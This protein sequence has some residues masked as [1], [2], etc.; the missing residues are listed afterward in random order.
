MATVKASRH[1]RCSVV[2]RAQL[3]WR[4]AQKFGGSALVAAGLLIAQPALADL[5][6][7]EY[8]AGGEFGRGT[9]QQYGEATII[10]RDFSNQQLQRSNFTAAD[11]RDCNFT[12]SNLQGA[13]FIKA[14]VARA[15]FKGADLSDVLMDRA[16]MVESD[17]TGAI[18]QRAVLTRSD[19]RDAKIDGTDFTNALIDKT[20]QMALCKY[21]SGVNPVTGGMLLY[22]LF[23]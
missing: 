11:C 14:V 7:F 12:K 20:Q 21:A 16:T 2:P 8:E 6:K 15:N 13:Y 19:L 5:N 23:T 4:A 18:L 3:D 17:L 10:G 1:A 22:C 9:A